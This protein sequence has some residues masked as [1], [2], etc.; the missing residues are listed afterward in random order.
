[1]G[2]TN[3]VVT[4]SE[5]IHINAGIQRCIDLVLPEASVVNARF[6]AACGMRFTTA[7][8][9]HDL[10]VGALTQALPGEVPAGGGNTLVISYISTSE[11]GGS[12]RVVVANPV[13]GGSARR[14]GPRRHLRHRLFRRV[15]AQRAGRGAGIRSARAGAPLSG[16]C[17]DSEGAGQYRG[18]FGASYEVE[19]PASQRGRGD[20]RQGSLQLSAV[21]ARSAVAAAASTAISASAAMRCTISANAPSIAPNWASSSACGAA[22]AAAMATRWIATRRRWRPTWWRVWCRCRARGTCMAWCWLMARWT[23]RP[24]RVAA[25]PCAPRAARRRMFD[26]GPGRSE[27]ERVHATAAELIAAWLPSLPLGV[28]RYAQGQVYR[29]LHELGPGPYDAPLVD[30]I[31]SSMT[32]G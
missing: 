17:P 21:G 8:R 4:K 1:M 27:W 15:P 31:L 18:G 30:D 23:K 9:V 24:R 3:F 11:L 25:R 7:M 10:V 13:L 26:F 12:G 28:R 2:L 32:W 29:R 19:D 6:P 22:V 20:A 5:A 16:W 14:A